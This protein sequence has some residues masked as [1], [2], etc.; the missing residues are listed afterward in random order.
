[1]TNNICLVTME[2]GKCNEKQEII[3]KN[4]LCDENNQKYNVN[5]TIMLF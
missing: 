3:L 5:E 1:M 4:L 2:M